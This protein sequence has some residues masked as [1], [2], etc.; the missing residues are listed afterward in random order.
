MPAK[1]DNRLER[2]AQ[3]AAAL[4]REIGLEHM[5]DVYAA[6]VLGAAESTGQTATV[7][8]EL[9]GLVTEVLDAYPDF[10]R[11]LASGMISHEE[12]SGIL[13]RVLGGRVS[14]LVMNFLKVISSHGRMKFLRVICARAR[15]L[16]QKKLGQVAVE[17]ATATP[18]DP[19]TAARLREALAPLVGG[20]PEL[21]E[22]VDPS[23]IG[24]LVVRVGD[25]VYDASVARQLQTLR[26][27]VIDRSAHEIQSRR[28]RFR[29][30][31]GN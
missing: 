4:E 21:H 13:D 5:A 6:A 22:R 24:G 20:T 12:R 8:D 28:D 18:L 16:Y 9:D 27:Q 10:E 26:Q 14:P 17:V 15:T 11:V 2:D 30:P 29:Y 7:L 1:S 23:V 31:A 25:T 3:L 19:D